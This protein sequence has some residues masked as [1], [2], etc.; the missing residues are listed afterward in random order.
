[1]TILDRYIARQYLINIFVLMALLASFVVMVDLSLN[2]D[3][4]AGA[5][6][7]MA[8]GEAS[9]G[10]PATGAG[11][12]RRAVITVLL[13]AD[14]WWPR[15]LQLFNFIA[16]LVVVGAMGF[17]FAQLVRHREVV[18][19]LAGGVSL[20]RAARPVLVVAVVVSA[21]QVVNQELV[22]PRIAPLL[23]RSAAAAGGRD[24]DAFSVALVAD[25]KRRLFQAARFDPAARTLE[26]MNVWERDEAGRAVRRVSADLATFD[27]SAGGWW[28]TNGW[29][30][31]LS[32]RGGGG[33]AAQRPQSTS[34]ARIETDLD[35]TTLLAN[36]F[37][38][39]SQT[40]SWVQIARVLGT[41]GLKADVRERLERVAWGRVSGLVCGLLSLVIAMRFYLTREPLNMVVQSLRCA[42]V[43]I[44]SIMAGVL[45]SALP[46]PGLPPVVGVF[47]PVMVLVPLAI[48]AASAIRT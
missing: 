40:L 9:D 3:K 10:A 8:S 34:V 15:L 38:A 6:A 23:T 31:D 28:L 1:M 43:A 22:L 44:L 16:P 48:E 19:M 32:V 20:Y 12:V 29:A 21:L 45:G 46:V 41:T 14:L 24:V 36:Q 17:T 39:F 37:S 42:P 26:R 30:I 4:F 7:R 27:E 13:V 18:A 35:P 25:G 33:A 11:A 47:L 5:A 2:L